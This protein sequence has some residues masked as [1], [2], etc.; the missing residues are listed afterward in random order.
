MLDALNTRPLPDEDLGRYNPETFG[1]FHLIAADD[2]KPNKDQ[3]GA[4][5]GGHQVV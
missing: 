1:A 4:I 2:F 5:I 3:V